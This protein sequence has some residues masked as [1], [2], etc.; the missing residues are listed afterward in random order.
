MAHG[1]CRI[2]LPAYVLDIYYSAPNIYQLI[3]DSY[4]LVAMA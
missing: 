4:L 3:D 1:A 2:A